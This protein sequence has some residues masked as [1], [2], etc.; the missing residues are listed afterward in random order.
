MIHPVFGLDSGFYYTNLKNSIYNCIKKTKITKNRNQREK[1]S[2]KKNRCNIILF[3]HYNFL[4]FFF[5]GKKNKYFVKKICI[6]IA[7]FMNVI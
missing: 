6:S 2:A 1:P 7:N 5:V 4:C 3:T